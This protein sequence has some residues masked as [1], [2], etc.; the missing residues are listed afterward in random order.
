MAFFCELVLILA[1]L[2]GTAVGDGEVVEITDADAHRLREGEWMI[3]LYVF[4]SRCPFQ[5]FF[6]MFILANCFFF[7]IRFRFQLVMH[8]GAR[9]ASNSLLHGYHWGEN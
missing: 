9:P 4:C 2:L 8:H 6:K 1:C 3:K 7:L 5:F